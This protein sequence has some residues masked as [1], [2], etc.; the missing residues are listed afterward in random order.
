MSLT[1]SIRERRE[2]AV[3]RRAPESV[4]EDRELLLQIEAL[5]S[6][7]TR[8]RTQE[9]IRY[10]TPHDKQQ[11]FYAA[12]AEYRIRLILG[13]NRSGKSEC[14]MAE[15]VAHAIG[16]RPWLDESDPDYRVIHKLTGKPLE[17]PNRGLIVCE[18]FDEQ[19]KKV[20]IPK[21]L[22][23][24]GQ[25]EGGLIPTTLV[26]GVKRNQT[27]VIT[28]IYLTN[29]STIFLKSYAQPVK[30]FESENYD[31]YSL[32]EPPPRE[33]YIAIERGA[34]DSGAPI[35]MQLTPLSQAWIHDEL[36]SRDDVFK[37]HFDITDNIGYGLTAEAVAEFEKSLTED[38]KEMR[39]HG[40]FFHLQGLV[41]KEFGDIH[42]VPRP[43]TPWPRNDRW[44]Y[45]MHVDPHVRKRH[46]AVW[47][48]IRPDNVYFVIGAL[49]TPPETNLISHFADQIH[50]Y[51]QDFLKLRQ[52]DIERL[53]DPLAV[54]PSVVG[55]GAS[56]ID[57]FG[58]SGLYFRTGSKD[59]ATAIQ[60]MHKLLHCR[61]AEGYYP[62][63]YV[64]NDLHEI[65]F[66]F[67]HYSFEEWRGKD[68]AERRDPNPDPR[69][70]FDDYIEGIHR[71]VLATYIPDEGENDQHE[72][73]APKRARYSTGY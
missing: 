9:R 49:Q 22:G 64:L 57:E 38:E 4:D 14:G 51:E 33:H 41:Y 28:E 58:A 34:T 16:Y 44:Q 62:Q 61:P 40:R 36:C 5:E 1:E 65:R 45:W 71:I 13:G 7:R 43:T 63:L 31:W 35:W 67:S 10:H 3:A 15:C 47:I 52:D 27:G 48:A 60:H 29:G 73:A 72:W 37:I 53:I 24:P 18:S 19:G 55:T 68:V 11:T 46:K 32:D 69:K 42:L 23:N 2:A 20:I 26:K 54:P 21:L 70:K 56:I 50:A 8:R 66:E 39:L 59:R 30:L 12:G 25:K 6:E 17:V